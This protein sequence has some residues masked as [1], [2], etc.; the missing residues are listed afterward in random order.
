[1]YR[2]H[3]KLVWIWLDDTYLVVNIWCIIKSMICASQLMCDLSALP[4]LML[5]F[6]LMFF[7]CNYLFPSS[8]LWSYLLPSIFI[9]SLFLSANELISETMNQVKQMLGVSIQFNEFQYYLAKTKSVNWPNPN[10]H[11]SYSSFWSIF[12]HLKLLSW[13]IIS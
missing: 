12:A 7:Y 8:H 6:V 1:M 3:T 4:E 2:L 11:F 9:L 5:Y 10:W 13:L